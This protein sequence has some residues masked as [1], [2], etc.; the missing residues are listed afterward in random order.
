MRFPYGVTACHG[1]RKNL[2][3]CSEPILRKSIFCLDNEVRLS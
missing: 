2:E 1:L 3:N